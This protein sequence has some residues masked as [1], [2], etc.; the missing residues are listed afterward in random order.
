MFQRMEAGKPGRILKHQKQPLV[1]NQKVCDGK[2]SLYQIK[3]IEQY[4]GK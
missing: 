2:S 4:A 1:A 3:G